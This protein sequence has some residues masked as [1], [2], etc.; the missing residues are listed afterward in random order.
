MKSLLKLLLFLCILIAGFYVATPLWLPHI[1]ARLL[2]QGWQLE[3][4]ETGYFGLS[5]VDINVLRVKGELQAAG[6]AL[7]AADIRFTYRG[8]KTEID[9]ISLDVFMQAVED[10]A[11]DALTLDDLSLPVTKL[12]GKIPEFSVKQM[13]MALHHDMDVVVTDPLVL[14]FRSFNLLPGTD[15]SYHLT[16]NVSIEGRAGF[17]GRLDVDVST[18]SRKAE[19]RFPAD[20]NSLPW[21]TV[22]LEQEDQAS[23]TTTRIRAAFEAE[24]AGQEWLDGILAQSTGGILTHVGGKLEAQADFAGKEL[25]DI[26]RLSLVTEQLRAEFEHGTLVLDADLMASR[27]GEK[28]TVTLPKPAEIQYQDKAGKING[29]LKRIVPG[30]QRTPRSLAMVLAEFDTTSSFVIQA[31][32]DPSMEFTGDVRLST[33]SAEGSTSFKATDLQVKISD[34]SSL[35]STTASGL[36]KLDWIE[37]TP[38]AYTS[39][40]LGLKADKLSLASTGHL[41]ITDQAIDFKQA[42]DFGVQFEGLQAKLQTGTPLKPAWLELNSD[43]Y[44]M[45]G[46]LDFSL[47][48]SEPD[49]PVNFYFDGPV[50]AIHP[51][52]RLPGDEHSPPITMVADEMSIAP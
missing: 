26:E 13:R 11:A 32:T 38:F 39:D 47:Q 9:S 22:S 45:Q 25:Q 4:L 24:A 27:E 51:V 46:R 19:I 29:L 35:D 1:V 41:Q 14:N 12:T 49:A 21:L 2:P 10:R 37:N 5:G 16:T 7:T 34:L 30:L 42:G 52:I 6:L 20:V 31:G 8:L 15:N 44:D 28:V 48:I 43:H 17:N 3:K 50:S 36:I 40:D 33:T 18:N 23:I